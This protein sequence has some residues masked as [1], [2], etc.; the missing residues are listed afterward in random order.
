M[1]EKLIT[2][3]ECLELDAKYGQDLYFYLT[4]NKEEKIKDIIKNT[5]DI[6]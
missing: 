1:E 2:S 5:N 4:L 3:I 6:V